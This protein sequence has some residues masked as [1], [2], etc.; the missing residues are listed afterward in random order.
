MRLYGSINNRFDEGHKFCKEIKVGTYVT[1]Y[2]WS[3]R[4]AYEVTKVIDQEHVTIRRLDAKR[5]DKNGMSECQDYQYIS[6]ENNASFDLEF[7]RGKWYIVRTFNK[8]EML[9][10]VE[11]RFANKSNDC[12]DK[13]KELMW[14]LHGSNFT[15]KQ[16]EKFNNGGSIKKYYEHNNISFGVADEYYDYSF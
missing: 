2:L 10:E 7:R 1:E 11:K 9:K 14:L 6:N 4:H 15:E 13:E 12:Y 3:D 16:Y 8:E 5:I